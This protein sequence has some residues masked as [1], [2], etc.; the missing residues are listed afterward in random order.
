MKGQSLNPLMNSIAHII[1]QKGYAKP[2]A[3]SHFESEEFTFSSGMAESAFKSYV[4]IKQNTNYI[5]DVGCCNFLSEKQ[6]G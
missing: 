1:P 5:M 3:G 4:M 6:R 2:G